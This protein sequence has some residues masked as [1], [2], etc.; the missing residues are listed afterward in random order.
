MKKLKLGIDVDGTLVDTM[1][2][3]LDLYRKEFNVEVSKEDLIL[4]DLSKIF[5]FVTKEKM[6]EYFEKAFENIDDIQLLISQKQI[7]ELNKLK[8]KYDIYI[9][10]SSWGDINKIKI[11]LDQHG[12][13]YDALIYVPNSEEKYKYCDILIDDK[14][15]NVKNML[16]HNKIGI[17]YKQPWSK[18]SFG[19][20]LK[21]SYVC[22]NWDEILQVLEKIKIGKF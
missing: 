7:N 2:K 16:K 5:P 12:I 21:A 9:I 10:T 4:Y 19:E 6:R 1:S 18:M 13:F 3:W 11:L 20:R 15:Q 17:L 22:E 8:R 14:A